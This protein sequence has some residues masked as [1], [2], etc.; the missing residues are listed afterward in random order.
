[1]REVARFGAVAVAFLIAPQVAAL[2]EFEA[3]VSHLHTV[4]ERNGVPA[5]TATRILASVTHLDRVI[6]ADRRQPEF[7]DTFTDY[8]S[9]A[10]SVDR[11]MRGRELLSE[12]RELLTRLSARY[13]V[14]G[15]Y[16]VALWGMESSYGRVLGSIRVFDSLA[17]LACDDRRGD[18]F[19][20]ELMHALRVVDRE[21]LDDTR[22]VGSWAG[23]MGQ[24]Q[25]MPSNYMRYAVDG[26]GDGRVDLWNSVPD[27]LASA[28]NFLSQLGWRSG[29]RWGREVS[30]PDGFDYY[31]AGRDR[32]RSLRE[33]RELGITDVSGRAL[34]DV[35]MD[36]SLL[37]PAGHR[38]PA[39]LVYHNFDVIMRWNRS[40]FFALSVG[41]LADRIA[42]SGGLHQT[43]PSLPRLS[44]A[45]IES[46][47][48]A[49]NE[50]GIDAGVAD[51]IFGPATRA[52]VREFQRQRGHVADGQADAALLAAL[53]ID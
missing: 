34:P 33:W 15:Q 38:G 24:T 29:E 1:M 42:G 30:V 43:P 40:E 31:L 8:F 45:Q 37:V 7:V 26:D 13:G 16:I 50:R 14:P 35:D 49:L 18:F 12:H 51:G 19:T 3:C 17:T 39:F 44:R 36:A 41:H 22:M 48:Q 4:A 23:A 10:V 25:F 46:M 52:A 9:R 5:A 53:G 11:I 20:D 27:A 6:E 21:Q 2:T 28:A 32:S 47:Q